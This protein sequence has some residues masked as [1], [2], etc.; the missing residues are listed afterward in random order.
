MI[1]FS[2][3]LSELYLLHGEK[4]KE[5]RNVS[6]ANDKVVLMDRYHGKQIILHGSKAK[7]ILHINKIIYIYI[8]IYV[9]YL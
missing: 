5:K 8:L 2:D 9:Y 4:L 1:Y 7:V 3:V 6:I